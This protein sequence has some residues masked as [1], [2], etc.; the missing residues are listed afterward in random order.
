MGKKSLIKS[1]SKKK[2]APKKTSPAANPKKKPP[3]KKAAPAKPNPAGQAK[4][5]PQPAKKAAPKTKPVS[6]KE[7]L[8]K[9][10]DIVTPK[11]LY[12]VPKKMAAKSTFT[13]PE[14][15]SGFKAED[16]KRVR[17]LLSNTYSEKD[18]KEAM[19]KAATEEGAAKKAAA[20]KAAAEKAAAEK[21]AAEKAAAE[22]AAAEKAAAE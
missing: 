3:K 15:L 14:F 22:K 1:T 18:L 9:K 16:A 11:V 12:T 17:R 19:K 13:A 5:A 21:A 20:E 7:L 6:V 8:R 2:R 4:P 10:F